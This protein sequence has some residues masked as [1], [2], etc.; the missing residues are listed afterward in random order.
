MKNVKF[1]ILVYRGYF[2]HG[3][4]ISP[5]QNFEKY[6]VIIIYLV[7][8]VVHGIIIATGLDTWDPQID[9]LTSKLLG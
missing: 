1:N 5:C 4:K 9:S 2:G 8:I 6:I 3:F 7:A